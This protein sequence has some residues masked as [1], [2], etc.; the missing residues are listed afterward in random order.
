MKLFHIAHKVDQITAA[1]QT[2]EHRTFEI[3]EILGVGAAGSHLTDTHML[4]LARLKSDGTF[5][6]YGV[7]W[8]QFCSDVDRDAML[9]EAKW[10]F[11]QAD[12]PSWM[13]YQSM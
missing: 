2:K 6:W 5:Y 8:Q 11:D 4:G 12:A 13:V 3:T 9:K 1:G 10:F 7:D